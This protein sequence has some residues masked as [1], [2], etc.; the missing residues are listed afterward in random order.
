MENQTRDQKF[1]HLFE[2]CEKLKKQVIYGRNI[3]EVIGDL[4]TTIDNPQASTTSRWRIAEDGLIHFSLTSTGETGA[5]WADWFTVNKFAVGSEFGSRYILRSASFKP[6]QVGTVYKIAVLPGN[7]FEKKRDWTSI[8]NVRAE[9]DRQGLK[10]GEEM[11]AEIAC[12]LRREFANKELEAMGLFWVV[13][14]H[15]PIADGHG[16]LS[17]LGPGCYSGGRWFSAFRCG[18]DDVFPTKYHFATLVSVISPP[19]VEQT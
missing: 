1:A 4:Q 17:L 16:F 9:A 7:L 11:N 8:S 18:P 5:Q 10:H 12:L 14:L 15:E 19:M 2:L 3:D 13:C 6:S